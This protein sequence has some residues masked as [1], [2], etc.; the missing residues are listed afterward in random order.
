MHAKLRSKTYS[1]MASTQLGQSMTE[2]III[3][4]VLLLITLGT[5]QLTLIYSAKATLNLAAFQ[6][7]RSGALNSGNTEKMREGLA[8]GLAPLFSYGTSVDDHKKAFQKSWEEAKHYAQ[9]KVV[10]PSPA[11]LKYWGGSIPNNNL[12]YSEE[13]TPGGLTVQD[14]NLLKIEVTYCYPLYVS[15]VNRTFIALAKGGIVNPGGLGGGTESYPE[16]SDAFHKICYSNGR[17]PIV[18]QAV[19]RMQTPFQA[20]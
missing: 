13:K 11:A 16:D 6:A 2:F 14:A 20:K 18:S 7:A 4:P 10:N 17:L 8:Q 1:M 5:L 9:I 19:V 3:F 15:L 12:R